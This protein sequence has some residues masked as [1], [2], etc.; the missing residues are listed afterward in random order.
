MVLVIAIGLRLSNLIK[1][2]IDTIVDSVIAIG[3]GEFDTPIQV[4]GGK[5][6]NTLGYEIKKMAFELDN[7]Y[8]NLE[9]RVRE[10]TNELELTQKN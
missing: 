3:K 4:S 7:L 6:I 8:E 9:K 1:E 2:P 10:R 5:E